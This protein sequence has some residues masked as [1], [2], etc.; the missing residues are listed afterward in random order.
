[1][2]ENLTTPAE[3]V[4]PLRSQPWL[5]QQGKVTS[6][7]WCLV[8]PPRWEGSVYTMSVP[9]RHGRW[10]E[11]D[12]GRQSRRTEGVRLQSGSPG[13]TP[14][15]AGGDA[16]STAADHAAHGPATRPPRAAAVGAVP[17]GRLCIMAHSDRIDPIGISQ[18]GQCKNALHVPRSASAAVSAVFLEPFTTTGRCSTCYAAK[19]RPRR[20]P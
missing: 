5:P 8:S 7:S 20:C 3:A 4:S 19:A 15:G 11:E 6:R 14:P 13:P 1:M 2:A 12:T 17:Y 10:G 18:A 9:C 16:P